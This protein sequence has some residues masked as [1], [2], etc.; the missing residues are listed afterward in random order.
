MPDHPPETAIH[1]PAWPRADDCDDTPLSYAVEISDRANGG[2]IIWGRYGPMIGSG[3]TEDR[4]LVNPPL[5]GLVRALLQR[6]V[7]ADSWLSEIADARECLG[8][9]GL[10]LGDA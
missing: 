3:S 10:E 2:C 9:R 1:L 6:M 5:R 8:V 4:W 7:D